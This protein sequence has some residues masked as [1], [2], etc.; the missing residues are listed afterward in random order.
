[1]V[2]PLAVVLRIIPDAQPVKFAFADKVPVAAVNVTPEA[3]N[4]D[5]GEYVD[6]P[7]KSTLVKFN[8]GFAA[9]IELKLV[10]VV[11]AP[12]GSAVSASTTGNNLL[13]M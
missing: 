13:S 9:V 11:V 2:P 7:E 4:E 3:L 12:T 6:S 8:A 10:N 1:M 5:A